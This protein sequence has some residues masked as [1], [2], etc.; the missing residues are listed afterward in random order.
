MANYRNIYEQYHGP[1][2]EDNDGRSYE[3]HHIDGNHSND[4]P[5][6][7]V[8]VTI[9][10]HYDIHYSQGDWGACHA[11][12]IRMKLSPIEIS[13]LSK[14]IQSQR[15]ADGTHNFLCGEIQRQTQKEK[16][17]NGIHNFQIKSDG[18]SMSSNRVMLGNHNFLGE[19]NPS[20]QKSKNGTHHW[21]KRSDGTSQATDRIANGTHHFIT[22]NPNKN[23]P[24]VKCP[25]CF[26][27]GG[28]NAMKQWHFDN[29]KVKP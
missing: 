2:P 4:E 19:N 13:E 7:L 20:R 14:K 6:N 11:I 16:S 25:Y 29:C 10:E 1:I 18:S 26:K 9:Q 5:D 23:M 28:R 22:N 3:I 27:E 24:L 8:A 21:K 15:I 17:A 12:A